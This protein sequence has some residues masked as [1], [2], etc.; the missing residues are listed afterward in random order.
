MLILLQNFCVH[1]NWIQHVARCSFLEII[2]KRT[3]KVLSVVRSGCGGSPKKAPG[4][5]AK[6]YDL[7]L[8]SSPEYKPQPSW[9]LRRC[10][11]ILANPFWWRY[12][13]A[14]LISW[15]CV[16]GEVTWPAVSGWGLRVYKSE[17]PGLEGGLLF[18]RGLLLVG[19]IDEEKEERWRL[20]FAE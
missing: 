15:S 19:D 1:E 9:E 13:P 16:P 8:T 20:K 14:A 3:K 6:S 5:A 7:H 4:T 10:T 17:R 2:A 18:K 11:R 12:A